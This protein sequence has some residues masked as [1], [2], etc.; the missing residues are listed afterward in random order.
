MFEG[1]FRPTVESSGNKSAFIAVLI[2]LGNL[3]VL[4]RYSAHKRD[5]GCICSSCWA[6]CRVHLPNGFT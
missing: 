1:G 5:V 4:F 3:S 6:R 2:I